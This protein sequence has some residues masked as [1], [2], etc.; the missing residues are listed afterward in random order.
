M[1]I[2]LENCRCK[3]CG[4]LTR[5]LIKA[6]EDFCICLSCIR[7]MEKELTKALAEGTIVNNED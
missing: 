4:N 7:Q 2:V 1:F 6:G 3:S 5:K